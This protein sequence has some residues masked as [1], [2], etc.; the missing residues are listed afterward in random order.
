MQGKRHKTAIYMAARLGGEP[1]IDWD[2]ARFAISLIT[3]AD[4]EVAGPAMKM[5]TMHFPGE[6]SG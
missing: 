4:I 2:Y 1:E 5:T 6:H 3:A